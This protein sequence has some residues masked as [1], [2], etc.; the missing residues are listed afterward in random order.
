MAN[1]GYARVSTR[2]Q[3][4]DIQVTALEAAG[5]KPRDIYSDVGVSG[6]LADRPGLARCLK[7]LQAGDTLVVWK[8]DRLGRSVR[9]LVITVNDLDGRGVQFRSLTEGL[10]TSTNG[11]RLIFHIFAALAEFERGLI[12]ERTEAGLAAAR[13]KGRVGGRPH[14][15]TREQRGLV[16]DLLAAGH[17]V[18]TVAR[19]MGTSRGTVYRVVEASARFALEAVAATAL[20]TAFPQEGAGRPDLSVNGR[21][22]EAYHDEH[23]RDPQDCGGAPPR[24]RARHRPSAA[25]RRPGR[26]RLRRPDDR[27]R[28]DRAHDRGQPRPPSP[29]VRRLHGRLGG[30]RRVRRR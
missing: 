8:L 29:P 1:I 18:A 6:R 24:H 11:G 10:D 25:V 28:R 26:R 4:L 15:L 19:K 30:R 23:N 14:S 21:L 17:N 13:A 12:V 20:R 22:E 16:L 7:R 3:R 2:D 9:H 27:A 5:C